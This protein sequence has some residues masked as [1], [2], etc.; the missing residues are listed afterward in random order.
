MHNAM[1]TANIQC[2]QADFDDSMSGEWWGDVTGD[3]AGD[4]GGWMGL[5]LG[6][7]G[8][9]VSTEWMWLV[10]LFPHP[11]TKPCA[12]SHPHQPAKRSPLHKPKRTPGTTAIC[13][14]LRGR[15]LLIAN[16]GDSRA[17]MAE[18]SGGG[19]KMMARDLSLDQTPYRW[20][21]GLGLGVWGGGWGMVGVWLGFGGGVWVW[22]WVWGLG[23]GVGAG[24]GWGWGRGVVQ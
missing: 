18:R 15:T 23:V 17:V 12:S 3:A 24:I 20:G 10:D 11:S 2:H 6:G 19:D 14:L 5:G 16:V 4:L 1:V 9:G 22:G 13:V 8:G 7:G 21:W